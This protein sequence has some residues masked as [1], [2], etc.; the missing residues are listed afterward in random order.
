V[1]AGIPVLTK[2]DLVTPE[3]L[4]ALSD[5]VDR[6][7][8]VSPV[9][10]QHPVPTSVRT[11]EGLER[12]RSLIEAGKERLQQRAADDLFRLPVDRAFSVAGVGTVVTGT[13]WSG[14]LELGEAVTILPGG[15]RG[16]VRSIEH[17]GQAVRRS[18]P[19][20]RTAVGLA[21][22]ERSAVGRGAA[23]VAE[24][25]PWPVTSVI[26]AELSL[27]ADAPHALESRS[28]VRVLLGTGEVM[29]RVFPRA[30]LEPGCVVP[31]RLLLER[32]L[33]ARGGDRLVIRN[34]SPVATIGGGWVLD[35]LPPRRASW[36]AELAAAAPDARMR[37]LLE[38]RPAGM[39]EG[40]VPV[41]L[42]LPPA[43]SLALLRHGGYAREVG[44]R[45]VAAATVTVAARRAVDVLREFHT[46]QPSSAGMPLETLRRSLRAPE[47]VARAALEDLAADRSVRAAG[48][49][50]ALADFSVEVK[51]GE[52]EIDRVV[53]LLEQADLAPPSLGEMAAQG[54]MGDLTAV[55]RIAAE[56]GLV[57]AV[58]RD[59]YYAT[60]ALRRFSAALLEAGRAGVISPAML[61]DRLGVSRKYLIPLLEWADRQGLTVRIAEGRRLARSP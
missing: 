27:H 44:D 6:R 61:R 56:R 53:R 14:T 8:A 26:D 45:W 46:R 4:A 23:L 32:P 18:E 21:G 59:R 47:L 31:A 50:A 54:G 57:Q 22:V 33:V 13:A 35:P 16:R 34:Y 39:P 58:E 52:R 38:R 17:H 36:P 9:D 28:R 3:R 40:A 51:G 2:L 5:S 60:G 49:V 15:I 55:L 30:A 48:G 25:V 20:A 42:G 12:I 19:G 24:G 29:A 43:Q 37:G 10:F 11:G 1:P 41:L 7:L